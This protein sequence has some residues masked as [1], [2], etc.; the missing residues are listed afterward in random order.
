M[1]E[2]GS[3]LISQW[4]VEGKITDD[5]EEAASKKKH[6]TYWKLFKDCAKPKSNSLITVVELKRLFQG[7]MTWEQFV[8]KATL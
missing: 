7:S 5:E 2:G 8:T 3:K 4:T 1:G 6:K